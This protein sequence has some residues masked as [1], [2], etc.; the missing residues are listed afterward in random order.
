[1]WGGGYLDFSSHQ[2]LNQPNTSEGEG[3]WRKIPQLTME[4]GCI[5][6][7]N[8]CLIVFEKGCIITQQAFWNM[9]QETSFHL[10]VKEEDRGIKATR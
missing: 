1:M 3:G 8:F 9:M 5:L 7:Q 10:C 2:P 6:S 4:E